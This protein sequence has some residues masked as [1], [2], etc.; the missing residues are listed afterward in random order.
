MIESQHAHDERCEIAFKK[1]CEELE[2][3]Q[4]EHDIN[5]YRVIGDSVALNKAKN[6]LMKLSRYD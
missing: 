6:E 3:L 5:W 2:I 4:L 1:Y